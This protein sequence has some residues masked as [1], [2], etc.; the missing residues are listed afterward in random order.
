MDSK[1]ISLGILALVVL[2][3]VFISS[4]QQEVTCNPPYIKVGTTCC[5]DQNNNKICDTDEQQTSQPQ[6][7]ESQQKQTNPCEGVVCPDYCKGATRYY[8]GRCINGKCSY[9]SMYCENGCK[10]GQCITYKIGNGICETDEENADLGMGCID[11][12]SVCDNDH[13]QMCV[14]YRSS[15]IGQPASISYSCQKTEIKLDSRGFFIPSNW[16]GMVS[17]IGTNEFKTT[18]DQVLI[19]L[20]V[21]MN[22]PST[23][24]VW[25]SNT[26]ETYLSN[27]KSQTICYK[28]DGSYALGEGEYFNGVY[29]EDFFSCDSSSEI[30][31]CEPIGSKVEIVRKL[32]SYGRNNAYSKVAVFYVHLE[33]TNVSGK[34]FSLNCKS[35]I[36]SEDIPSDIKEI[37]FTVHF[38]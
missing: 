25:K 30:W 24:S 31:S 38:V 10:N 6:Q 33:G 23:T 27:I 17:T 16:E 12:I 14:G 37:T 36:W 22:F 11:C 21:S 20:F 4:R 13:T 5:L 3:F 2:G 28:P 1:Y 35:R 34:P 9:D 18:S 8:N 29:L 32:G 26:W 19:G 7:T 15:W